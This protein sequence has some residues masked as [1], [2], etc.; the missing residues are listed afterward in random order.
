MKLKKRAT[1][2]IFFSASQHRFR[3]HLCIQ[4][5]PNGEVLTETDAFIVK[6]LSAMAEMD[7]GCG[8]GQ[9][10]FSRL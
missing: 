1:C 3:E 6:C 2:I 8:E 7:V 9:T 4:W 5:S 10:F